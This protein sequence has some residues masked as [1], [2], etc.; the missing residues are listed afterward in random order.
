MLTLSYLT[1]TQHFVA[2]LRSPFKMADFPFDSQTV[3]LQIVSF[4]YSASIIQFAYF[5]DS[6]G[7]PTNPSPFESVSSDTWVLQSVNPQ[8]E[9]VKF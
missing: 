5:P 2:T 1:L 6:L 9:F 3:F 4:K 8:G 7:G